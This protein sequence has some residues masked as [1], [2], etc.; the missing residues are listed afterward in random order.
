MKVD[1]FVLLMISIITLIII[2]LVTECNRG[3]LKELEDKAT[4]EIKETFFVHLGSAL[5]TESG[6]KGFLITDITEGRYGGR[7]KQQVINSIGNHNINDYIS[8]NEYNSYNSNLFNSPTGTEKNPID[9]DL[10]IGSST[11][12]NMIPYHHVQPNDNYSYG[13]QNCQDKYGSDYK[14]GSDSYNL[15]NIPTIFGVGSNIYN[16]PNDIELNGTIE[17]TNEDENEVLDSGS[18][19]MSINTEIDIILNFSNSLLNQA[20]S[21]NIVAS[22]YGCNTLNIQ[23][24]YMYSRNIIKEVNISKEYPIDIIY[25]IQLKTDNS[26]SN[27]YYLEI[28][29][30]IRL[31]TIESY[32][33]SG[34]D[35]NVCDAVDQSISPIQALVNDITDLND[36]VNNFVNSINNIDFDLIIHNGLQNQTNQNNLNNDNGI[37]LYK[38]TSNTINNNNEDEIS[39]SNF[40]LVNYN[41]QNISDLGNNFKIKLTKNVENNYTISIIDVN[42]GNFDINMG[43]NISQFKNISYTSI[44]NIFN[45]II[46][47]NQENPQEDNPYYTITTN[48]VLFNLN[49]DNNDANTDILDNLE[50]KNILS[51]LDQRTINLINEL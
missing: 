32:I 46:Q 3:R 47:E 8:E 17:I 31:N 36:N 40:N 33:V 38:F 43:P 1:N 16:I 14:Y 30:K 22:N 26:N 10:I 51:K 4:Q 25:N 37:L 12:I 18:L 9:C 21:A 41:Y 19:E 11:N 44:Q 6:Q 27:Q 5:P 2:S 28:E 50:V 42:S 34:V 48:I 39:F 23:P 24:S 15:Y 13:G 49:V 20:A 35:F 29:V 45:D 7:S